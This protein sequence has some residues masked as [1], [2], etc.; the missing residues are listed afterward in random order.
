[1]NQLEALPQVLILVEGIPLPGA[2]LGSLS[3]VRVQQR[4]SLPALCE[5]TFCDPP[6]ALTA[7]TLVAVGVKLQVEVLGNL[8]PLFSGQVTA[9]EY[10]YGPAR[11]REL[12]VRGYDLLH[13]LRKR[14]TVKAH[15]QVTARELAQELVAD[16]GLTVEAAGDGPLWPRLIQHYQTDLELLQEV[17]ARC[18]L[19]LT[20]REN[21]L[22]LLTLEG[23]GFPFPLI[24]GRSLL[25]ARIEINSDASCRS[26]EATGWDPLRVEVHA[27]RA[28]E[29]RSGRV[30]LA[31]A[32]PGPVGGS[33]QRELVGQN[34]Q[35]DA[36]AEGLAQA[37]LDRRA[38]REVTLRGVAQGNPV[39]R[40]GQKVAVAEVAPFVTGLYVLTSVNHIIDDKVGFISEI[41][42][43]PPTPVVQKHSPAVSA[44]TVTRIDDPD[45]LGRV[46]VSLP[47]YR[48]VETG[49]ME[50]VSVGA[51]QGKGLIA[52]PDVGDQ[53]LVLFSQGDPAQGVVL[54][55]LYG[56]NGPPDSGIEGGEVRR[57]TLVTPGGQRLALDDATKTIR[58]ET[59][60][61][62]Y[63]EFAPET[64]KLH[65]EADLELEAPGHRVVIRGQK[66]DFEKA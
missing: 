49:W 30:T 9:I 40:P 6:L 3:E 19:Y 18:G 57:Y 53:V 1:M 16:L 21:T 28:A 55:G 60:E 13:V 31:D 17:T 43:S 23:T 65:A 29:A 66:I 58:L 27:G 39:L 15:V 14:Q 37:E 48:D 24:L 41:S 63:I 34:A 50:V 7:A 47:V 54:G 33:E 56:A 52:L 36:H 35:D 12:R 64:I 44:G 26:V 4:L 32:P 8:V 20:L 62:S 5:L 38:A 10:V 59:S 2:L 45:K 25:E 42:T 46:C 11:E 22:H 51:G 61:K